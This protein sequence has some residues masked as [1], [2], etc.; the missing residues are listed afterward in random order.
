MKITQKVR[1]FAAEKGVPES[2]ALAEGME[3]KAAEFVRSGA[4]VYRKV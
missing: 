4:E 2:D 1:K 3:S